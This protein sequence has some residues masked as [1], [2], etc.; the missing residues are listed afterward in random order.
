MEGGGQQTRNI[1]TTH[2]LKISPLKV[3]TTFQ[4]EPPLLKVALTSQIEHRLSRWM[5]G[6][7]TKL[8]TSR[9]MAK[10]SYGWTGGQSL[11]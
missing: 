6:H 7:Y 3:N 11:R 4:G 1:C 9:C 8:P 2:R 10:V 5:D